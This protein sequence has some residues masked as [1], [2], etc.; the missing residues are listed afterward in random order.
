MKKEIL[1][2]D[3]EGYKRETIEKLKRELEKDF[4]VWFDEI[5]ITE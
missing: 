4:V 2:I 5:S 1:A 3:I